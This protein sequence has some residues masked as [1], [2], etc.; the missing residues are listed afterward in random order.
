MRT[1]WLPVVNSTD[2]LHRFKRTRLFC[3]KTESGFCACAITFQLASALVF[4]IKRTYKIQVPVDGGEG[5]C[6]LSFKCCYSNK[7]T[8]Q[9]RQ[10]YKFITWRFVSLNVFRAPPRPSS[11][12]YSCINSLW[13]YL[14]MW[15]YQL[16]WLW[17]GRLWPARPQPTT[18]TSNSLY[19]LHTLT[20]CMTGHSSLLR[21]C[22]GICLCSVWSLFM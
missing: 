14:G 21:G 19:S 22:K 17:S 18:P 10:F 4:Q 11:G 3:W 16:C 5:Y 9:M 13:V 8:D 6:G 15:W 1:P 2:A 12:A 7:L 20:Y